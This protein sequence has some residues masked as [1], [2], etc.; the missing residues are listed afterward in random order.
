MKITLEQYPGLTQNL[1]TIGT[2]D[3]S[4]NEPALLALLALLLNAA[5]ENVARALSVIG[6]EEDTSTTGEAP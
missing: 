1:V 6:E 2:V 3:L 5:L 4:D